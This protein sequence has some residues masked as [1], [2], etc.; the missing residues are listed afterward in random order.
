MGEYIMPYI[1]LWPP[2]AA[3][4]MAGFTHTK[5]SQ[6]APP[7]P[8]LHTNDNFASQQVSGFI[9]GQLYENLGSF[10]QITGDPVGG[11]VALDASDIRYA[12]TLRQV[13]RPADYIQ[14]HLVY[15]SGQRQDAG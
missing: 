10:I 12:D 5:S 1:V 6:D 8:G 9:A 4:H 3:M 13:R 11:T 14:S 7:A 2:V 15:R